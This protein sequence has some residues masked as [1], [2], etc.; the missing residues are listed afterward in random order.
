MASMLCLREESDV[1]VP[2][3]LTMGLAKTLSRNDAML[4]DPA[5][6][7]CGFFSL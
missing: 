1:H 2:A 5:M 7:I 3:I 4:P 6:T